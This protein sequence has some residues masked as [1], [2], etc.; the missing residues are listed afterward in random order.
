MRS[1][2]DNHV[3][4]LLMGAYAVAL[5]GYPR[6]TKDINIWIDMSP[7][8]AA[9][10]VKALVQFGFDSLGLQ[11]ADF[12]V[13]EQMIQLDYPSNRIDRITTP[14]QEPAFMPDAFLAAI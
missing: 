2:N 3:R 13:S 12:L 9:N 4:Y 10:M 8:T 7:E 11:A 6:Y 14:H 1:L 5:H